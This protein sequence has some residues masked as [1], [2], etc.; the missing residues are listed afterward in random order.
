MALALAGECETPLGQYAP[1]PLAQ[2]FNREMRSYISTNH[3][4][5][6]K[7]QEKT[8]KHWM[9]DAVY[10]F[11]SETDGEPDRRPRDRGTA[12]FLK[13]L[14]EF[15]KAWNSDPPRPGFE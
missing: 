5:Y 7:S 3:K 10:D 2:Q 14:G 9:Q 8:G 1:P 15:F 11:D 6:I 12:A 13:D 4:R